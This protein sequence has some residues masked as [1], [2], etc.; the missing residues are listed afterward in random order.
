LFHNFQNVFVL[1]T[2][3]KGL[4]LILLLYIIFRYAKHY[5]FVK[6]RKQPKF[7]NPY[8][9][10]KPLI[11]NYTVC[12]HLL[13]GFILTS[14]KAKIDYSVIKEV[15]SLLDNKSRFAFTTKVDRKYKL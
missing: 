10:F 12:P 9:I 2:I 4:S 7:N 11:T 1:S 14:F 3:L 8:H 6:K 5:A 13:G 15:L